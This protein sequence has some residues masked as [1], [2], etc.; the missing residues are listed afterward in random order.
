MMKRIFGTVI[1][2]LSLIIP[3]AAAAQ[4]ANPVEWRLQVAADGARVRAEARDASA[5]LIVLAKGTMLASFERSGDWYRV[6]VET[7]EAGILVVGYIAAADVQVVKETVRPRPNFWAVE[8]GDY[9][10]I[11]LSVRIVVGLNRLGGGDLLAGSRG[12]FDRLGSDLAAG[13][14]ILGAESR[15]FSWTGANSEVEFIYRLTPRLGIGLGLESCFENSKSWREYSW[16]GADDLVS[17]QTHMTYRAP[18]LGLIC[19]LPLGRLFG[20]YAEGGVWRPMV[21]YKST[22]I[23]RRTEALDVRSRGFGYH[24]AL[25]IELTLTS[26]GYFFVEARGRY[27]RLTGFRG[28]STLEI[29]EPWKV[30]VSIVRDGRLYYLDSGPQASLLIQPGGEDPVDGSREAV[31]PLKTIGVSA[32]L[33]VK[34]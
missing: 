3:A 2:S 32:G 17:L 1:L 34:F 4:D 8:S 27:G 12:M 9:H 11:G 28:R 25:G 19:T 22:I 10:G 23:G 29:H 15:D 26:R 7:G 21:T 16:Y 5:E 13:G 33:R 31:L 24:G 6:V 14:Y 18:R 20:I 30:P